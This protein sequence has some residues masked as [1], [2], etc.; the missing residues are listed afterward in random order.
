MLLPGPS[1]P[2]VRPLASRCLRTVRGG[3]SVAGVD[4]APCGVTEAARAPRQKKAGGKGIVPLSGVVGGLPAKRAGAVCRGGVPPG[5]PDRLWSSVP[6]RL[7][8]GFPLPADSPGGLG[9]KPPA[10]AGWFRPAVAVDRGRQCCSPLLSVG[11][12]SPAVHAGRLAAL[13]RVSPGVLGRKPPAR[14]VAVRPPSG[15]RAR[16][17]RRRC[18]LP[19]CIPQAHGP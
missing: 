12:V 18:G 15:Q 5:L 3:L 1:D 8:S 7:A 4:T 19:G 9:R 13:L 16:R 14:T 17:T 2:C 10:G 6:G 11:S